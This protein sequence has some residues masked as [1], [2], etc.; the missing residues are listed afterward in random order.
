MDTFPYDSWAQALE[1]AD[2]TEGYFTWGPGGNTM[3]VI[4]VILGIA[5]ALAF[6]V[7]VTVDEEEHLNEVAEGAHEK[8]GL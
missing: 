3:S 8:W 1:A 4:L 7:W 5:L 2:G 6:M